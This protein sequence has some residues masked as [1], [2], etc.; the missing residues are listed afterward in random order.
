MVGAIVDAIHRHQPCT[1]P[2]IARDLNRK[3]RDIKRQLK[4]LEER[5]LVLRDGDTYLLPPNFEEILQESLSW[6]GT[7]ETD[8]R[9]K[10]VYETEREA[11]NLWVA[12]QQARKQEKGAAGG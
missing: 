1:R 5:G 3:S 10:R 11:N 6:D 4:K 2:E 12:R 7:L 9:H 8:K